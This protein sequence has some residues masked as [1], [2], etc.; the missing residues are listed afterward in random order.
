M[1]LDLC[2][3]IWQAEQDNVLRPRTIWKRCG[4]GT[5]CRAY[6]MLKNVIDGRA[7]Y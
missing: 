2:Y 4:C 6:Q 5:D 1:R 7:T 3:G